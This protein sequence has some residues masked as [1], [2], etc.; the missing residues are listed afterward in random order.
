MSLD[1]QLTGE[2]K[3]VRCTC[4]ECGHVHTRNDKEVLFSANIT[5]NLNTMAAEAGIY[6]HLWR[7]DE[8]EITQAKQLI[9]PL[10]KGLDLMKSDPKRFKEFDAPNKW[11]LYINFVPWVENYLRACRENPEAFVEVSR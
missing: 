5:H 1:V 6:K 7:P 2:M 8:I 4:R 10:Q 3:T 11:G 9:E